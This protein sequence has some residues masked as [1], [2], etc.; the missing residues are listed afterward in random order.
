MHTSSKLLRTWSQITVLNSLMY[1]EIFFIIAPDEKMHK[2]WKRKKLY[3][4]ENSNT[5]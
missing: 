2:N 3:I 1:H 4:K 5:K